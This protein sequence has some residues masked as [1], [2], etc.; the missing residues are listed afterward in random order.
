V[1]STI[2]RECGRGV[3]LHAGPEFGVAA[4]KS[5]TNQLLV[6]LQLSI[7]FGRKRGMSLRQGLELLDA[8][9]R[10]P[11][12]AADALKQDAP[13]RR[14]A[15]SFVEADHFLYVGRGMEYPIALEGALKL[16]EVSYIHAEGMAAAE[17]KH[18][19]IALVG[20]DMPTVVIATQTHLLEK[21]ASN[22]QE[23]RARGGRIIAIATETNETIRQ[24]S[25]HFI[26]VPE[27]N[28][29]ISPILAT[30]PTQLL[31]Y[32]LADLRGCD[33]DQPRN[34]AKSVTVE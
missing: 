28:D 18:G 2:A 11:D 3:Y 12:L 1:G 22:V 30:I 31:A 21:I 25:D 33:V 8:L 34:L 14:I 9:D 7:H 29:L 16:K 5:F 10:L 23:I 26:P 4:T 20:E 17:L 6:L 13:I 24:L 32:H 19:P 27:A 15:E